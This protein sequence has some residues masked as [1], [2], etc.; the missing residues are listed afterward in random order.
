MI[1]T[2]NVLSAVAVALALGAAAGEAQ[3]QFGMG[4]GMRGPMGGMGMMGMGMRGGPMGMGM[5]SRSMYLSSPPSG[6]RRSHRSRDFVEDEPP[7]RQAKHRAKPAPV[8]AAAPAKAPAARVVSNPAL[9]AKTLPQYQPAQS[10]QP[11]L[12]GASQPAQL[13][14]PAQATPV[15]QSV[16]APVQQAAAPVAPAGADSALPVR[17]TPDTRPLNCMTKL[18]LKD[19]TVLLQDFCTLEQHVIKQ[20]DRP[21]SQAVTPPPAL[22]PQQVRKDAAPSQL[23][24]NR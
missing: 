19:G 13:S 23:A 17:L 9:P 4:M 2:R 3:A 11:V 22:Q 8:Q 20:P 6:Y 21:Q 15:P 7:A 12:S 5:G 16:P 24:R 14:Q 10:A 1:A 18:H